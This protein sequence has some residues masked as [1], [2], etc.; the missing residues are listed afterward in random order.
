MDLEVSRSPN[1]LD[2][3]PYRRSVGKRPAR[4]VWNLN[5]LLVDDD[6]A[7][8][9]LILNVLKRHP[10]VST[11]RAT[12]APEFALRQ[13]ASENHLKPDLVLLDIQMPRMNGFNFLEAMRQIPSMAHV[14][15]VFLTTSRL[16]SDVARTKEGSASLY[17]IKPDS[18]FELQARLN[19]V[20]RRAASG[21]WEKMP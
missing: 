12:D 17:V 3:R 5:V 11:A 9:E 2:D 18:Y 19:G 14:P 4:R 15:V 13:L 7:D 21:R 10:E 1:Q 8:T 6:V 20:L 16:A